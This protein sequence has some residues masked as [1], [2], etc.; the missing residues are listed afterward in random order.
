MNICDRISNKGFFYFRGRVALYSILKAMHIGK[1]DSVICQAFTCVAVPEAILATGATP[2]YV[3]IEKDGFNMDPNLLWERIQSNTKA[4]IVQHTFGIPCKMDAIK[5]IAITAGVPIIEDCCHT[6]TSTYNGK[7]VG[8]FGEASFYSLEWG[9]PIVAGI[10]GIALLSSETLYHKVKQDYSSLKSPS[11]L[12]NLKLNIQYLAHSILYRPFF[13]WSLKKIFHFLS[14]CGVIVGN[15]NAI[16]KEVSDDFLLKMPNSVY[17]R[18]RL[19]MEQYDRIEKYHIQLV[20]MYNK[21]LPSNLG[22]I[23]P[24]L[25]VADKI[26]LTR[27]P[28]M[29]QYKE[30]LVN[31]A[32]KHNIELGDWYTT[33]V[34]PLKKKELIC[35]HYQIGSC[36]E[37]E[38]RCK[39]VVSLPVNLKV[40]QRDIDKIINFFKG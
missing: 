28:L 29:T 32:K 37:T 8:T 20:Q 15:Y 36:P 24:L 11:Y 23:K 27:Y 22:I 12:C 35:V 2:L 26:V 10:G 17:K 38:K 6:F 3:D 33:P 25:S 7:Q 18:M 1:E 16:K 34:H 9:K 31:K 39:E 14:R 21:Y 19:K 40:S 5:K 13:Y 4:I 30:E